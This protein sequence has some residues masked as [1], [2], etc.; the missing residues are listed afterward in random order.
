MLR[1]ANAGASV[2]GSLM[3]G[4]LTVCALATLAVSAAS[5]HYSGAGAAIMFADLGLVL[6]A[7]L[8]VLGVISLVTWL[9]GRGTGIRLDAG[10]ALAAVTAATFPALPGLILTPLPE[11]GPLVALALAGY[12]GIRLFRVLPTQAILSRLMVVSFSVAAGLI[13][14]V[15]AAWILQTLS[16]TPTLSAPSPAAPAPAPGSTF[17]PAADGRLTPDQLDRFIREAEAARKASRQTLAGLS[18][19][20]QDPEKDDGRTAV[21]MGLNF[22]MGLP[23]L[24]KQ[25]VESAGGNWQE[26]QWIQDRVEAALAHPGASAAN[27][28]NARL[29]KTRSA[30][31]RSALKGIYDADRADQGMP[32]N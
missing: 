23:E 22:V 9:I 28:Y 17:T 3:L 25:A 30:D 5:G 32:V 10:A 6:G 29:I 19:T 15:P 26:F 16:G 14:L 11:P 1:L 18:Q 2:T 21:R 13:A 8:L 24:Q 4:W 20:S 27:S 7:P 31:V 12:A